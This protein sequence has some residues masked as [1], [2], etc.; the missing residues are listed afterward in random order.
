MFAWNWGQ[1]LVK[2]EWSDYD[3]VDADQGGSGHMNKLV[4]AGTALALA[5]SAPAQAQTAKFLKKHGDWS[6]YAHDQGGKKTCFIVAQPRDSKPKNVKRDPIYFY[7]SNWPADKVSGE[8]SIKMGYPLKPGVPL[9][10]TIG[11][12]KVE[13]FTKGEGGY[14]EKASD[15]AK[16]VAAMKAGS[17]MVV[18]GRSTRGTLTTDEYS[19]T[20]TTDALNAS[21][22]ACK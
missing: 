10:I 5:L 21:D 20:G 8:I 15:E 6:V 9:Q 13:G 22:E 14:V 4:W 2:C 17:V 16:V 1:Y 3:R 18:R 12:T 19:L 7:V 11:D